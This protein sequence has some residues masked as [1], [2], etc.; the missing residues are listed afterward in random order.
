MG[1]EYITMANIF[2][3][4]FSLKHI[5]YKYVSLWFPPTI[6]SGFTS[7]F[8]KIERLTKKNVKLK[9]EGTN[10]YLIFGKVILTLR[11]IKTNLIIPYISYPPKDQNF[12]I[13]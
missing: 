5:Y 11:S 2:Y 3:M 12:L 4:M 10:Q 8:L 1:G 7:L 6:I 9:I 13:S